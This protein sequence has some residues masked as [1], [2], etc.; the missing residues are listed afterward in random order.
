MSPEEAE[1]IIRANWPS[2]NYSMLIEALE[3]VLSQADHN[4]LLQNELF[5]LR[6]GKDAQE[7]ISDLMAQIDALKEKLVEERAKQIEVLCK[8]DDMEGK[9]VMG[10][11]G[12][13]AG[14]KQKDR[15]R[16]LARQQLKAEM[17][18]VEWG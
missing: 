3:F 6:K 12:W 4:D 5:E 13:C 1:E 7:A 2:E 15:I 14:C 10:D 11:T 18:G 9:C 16:G 8:Y 17:P